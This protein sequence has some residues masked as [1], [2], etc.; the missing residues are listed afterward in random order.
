MPCLHS[1][2]VKH[3]LFEHSLPETTYQTI[4]IKFLVP[5][6]ESIIWE[7]SLF[8]KTTEYNNYLHGN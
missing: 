3:S 1:I 4:A 5:S 7:N 6:T 8:L 2:P